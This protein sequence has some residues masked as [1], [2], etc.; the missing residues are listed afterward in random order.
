MASYKHILIS[1]D[2]SE[3]SIK[4]CEKAN[5]LAQSVGAKLS[6]IHIVEYLPLMY[7]GGEF[8][9]P[10]E[11]DLEDKLAVEAK[12]NLEKQA[13]HHNIPKMNQFVMVGTIKE[14]LVKFVKTHQVDLV[15][16]GAH[17]RHGLDYLLGTTAD[18]VLHALPCDVLAVRI[19]T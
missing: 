5:T 4:L 3:Q 13:N 15:V 2:L 11:P 9:L 8:A 16:V 7:T 19:P 6:I 1:S 14:E 18:N 12:I 17:D 10:L